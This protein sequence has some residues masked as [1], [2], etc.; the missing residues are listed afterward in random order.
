MHGIQKDFRGEVLPIKAK[1][2]NQKSIGI[3][4][5][6][7]NTSGSF[8]YKKTKRKNKENLMNVKKPIF[9]SR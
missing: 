3:G 4:I 2:E 8:E 5:F 7:S 1:K 9:P 6:H